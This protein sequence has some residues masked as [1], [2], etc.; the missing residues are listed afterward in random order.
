MKYPVIFVSSVLIFTSMLFA[1]EQ[2][3]VLVEVFTN[4]HCP[5]C[6]GAH[7]TLDNYLAGPNGDK[8]SYIYYHMVYPYPSDSLYH[9]SKEG[10]DARHNYYNPIQATPRGFFDGIIQGSSSGWAAT[11]DNLVTTESPLKINISGS[12]NTNQFFLNAEVTRTG[13]VTDNDLVIHF[14]VVEDL[15]YAGNNGIS[16]HKHVMR[17]MFPTPNGQTFS[18]NLNETKDVEQTIDIDPPWDADSLNVVVFVQS[19]GSKTVYQSE[20]INY[21]DLTTTGVGNENS[22]PKEFSLQQNYPNPFNP[23]TSIKFTI[24][25]SGFTTLKVYNIL[26]NEV[27]TLISEELTQGSFSVKFDASELP[28]GVY[29]YT[30]TSNNFN[31]TKKMLLLK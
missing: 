29:L 10:S 7:N 19:S 14:V 12:R 22:L 18:I 11:L 9:Q 3:K 16:D 13:S 17:K 21:N 4:S 28:S 5:L 15:Y 20:T 2:R 6:P 1:Q 8:I 25:E 31:E 30:L 27:T 26:G 23:S 24:P